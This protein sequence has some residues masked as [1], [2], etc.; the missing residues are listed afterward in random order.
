MGIPIF[1]MFKVVYAFVELTKRL[2]EL[3]LMK[4]TTTEFCLLVCLSI[5]LSSLPFLGLQ[6][7]RVGLLIIEFKHDVENK[8]GIQG[9]VGSDHEVMR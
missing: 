9:H 2:L 3:P 8:M 5:R 6:L 7:T 1:Y 4:W